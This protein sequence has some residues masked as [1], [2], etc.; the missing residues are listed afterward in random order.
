[1]DRNGF[2]NRNTRQWRGGALIETE[3][4]LATEEPLEIRLAGRRFT[5]TMRTPGHDEELAAGFL[6][7]EGFINSRGEIAW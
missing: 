4:R 3:D 6:F 7:A 1:M 5:L 2:R